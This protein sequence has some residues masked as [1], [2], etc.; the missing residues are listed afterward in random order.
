MPTSSEIY[1]LTC[2]YRKLKERGLQHRENVRFYQK[3]PECVSRGSVFV[4]VG[5]VDCYPALFVLIGGILSAG[6]MLLLEFLHNYSSA[7]R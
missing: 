1:G 3:K 7:S 6:V 5:L 4:S 2:R